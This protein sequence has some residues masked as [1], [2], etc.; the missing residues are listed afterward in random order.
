MASPPALWWMDTLNMSGF[1][2]G[3]YVD[4]SEYLRLSCRCWRVTKANCN[5]DKTPTFHP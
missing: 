5:A 2:P 1:V 3:F 4:I